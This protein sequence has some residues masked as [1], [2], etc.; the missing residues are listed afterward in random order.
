MDG[1]YFNRCINDALLTALSGEKGPVHINIAVSEPLTQEMDMPSI[2]ERFVTRIPSSSIPDEQSMKPLCDEFMS[3]RKVLVLVAFSQPDEQLSQALLRLAE[4]PQVVVLTESIA[5]VRGKNLIPTIDRVYSVIDKAEWEDYAPDLLITLGGSLVS[6]MIKAFLRQ[7][8]P[9]L[10][11]RISQGDHVVDTMQSLTC[12][13]DSQAASFL[14]V[15]SRSVFPIESDYSML[16]HRKE[17]I[18]TRLHDDYIAHVGWC[19]LK[20][21]SLIL[22]AIPP[23][24]ALQLSNGTTVRYAQL[25][26]CEQVLR[27][28]CNRGVSGIEGSTS[29]AAGAACVGEEMTVLITGD[30]SFSYDVNGL[31]STYLSPRFKIIVMCNGG[32]GIFRFIKPTSDLPELETCFEIHRDISVEKYADLFGLRYFELNDEKLAAEVLSLFFAEKDRP[33]IL[34]VHT[35]NVY[36]AEVLRGY[37]RRSRQ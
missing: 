6:R 34:A 31:S 32:G 26:K 11:W 23:G 16:W 24:T 8:K 14:E 12:H 4:L 29:T 33:A 7:H 1:W 36:N 5:N 22:P 10:H 21:F 17:V 27:S 18:A 9:K 37:F 28:D 19:D 3:A 20:A 13:I 35:P 30:M 2:R 15:L 25:F